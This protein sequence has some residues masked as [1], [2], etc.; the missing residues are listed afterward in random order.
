MVSKVLALTPAFSHID[1]TLAEALRA[2]G[3]RSVALVGCSDLVKARSILLSQALSSDA[4]AFLLVDADMVV[5]SQHLDAIL[6]SEKVTPTDAVTGAYLSK[7]G[8]LCAVPIGRDPIEIGGSPRFHPCFAAGLGFSVVHRQSLETARTK[9]I[10]LSEVGRF[11]WWPFCLPKIVDAAFGIAGN[12][13][14]GEDYSFWH[15]LRQLAGVQLWLDTH[16][17]IGH[18]SLMPL[19]FNQGDM[20]DVNA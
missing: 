10:E 18:L 8:S 15:T 20:I 2:K 3:I 19:G 9:L 6:Q 12:R 11:P 7:Q 4:E 5:T 14:L 1:H 17:A 16:C 13:Y